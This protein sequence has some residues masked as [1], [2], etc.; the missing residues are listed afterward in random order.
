MR[1]VSGDLKG[2]RIPFNNQKQGNARVTSERV[3]E[4]VFAALGGGLHGRRVLD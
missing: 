4:A 3:K 1:V 2:R